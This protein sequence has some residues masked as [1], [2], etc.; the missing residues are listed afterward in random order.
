M[1]ND[2]DV[3]NESNNDENKN[4]SH[5]L[6]RD[7]LE[8]NNNKKTNKKPN[9]SVQPLYTKELKEDS[10]DNELSPVTSVTLSHRYDINDKSDTFSGLSISEVKDA[11]GKTKI[12]MIYSLLYLKPNLTRKAMAIKLDVPTNTITVTMNRN[13]GRFIESGNKDNSLTY[14]LSDLAIKEVEDKLEKYMSIKE[15]IINSK[16]KK[17]KEELTEQE[18]ENE[19]TKTLD[20]IKPIISNDL[21]ILD[22]NEVLLNSTKVA[23]YIISQPNKFIE[24]VISKY[25]DFNIKFISFKNLPKILTKSIEHIRAADLDRLICIEGRCVSISPTRGMITE[26]KFECPTCGTI[27][28]VIQVDDKFKEPVRCS[29]GRRGSFKI[30]VKDLVDASNL[31]LEDLQDNTEN[32]NTQRVKARITERLTRKENIGV[33]N[34]GEEIKITGILREVKTYVHGVESTSV[35]YLFE[36][37]DAEKK[38]EEVDVEEFTE[39]EVKEIK[40]LSNKINEKG[41]DYLLPSF[42]PDVYGCEYIKKAVMLQ[43]CNCKNKPNESSTRNKP[44]ILLIGDPGIAKSVISKYVMSITPGSRKASGG[45][46]SAVGITA[47][48]VKEDDSLGGY[49]IEAG[50]LPLAK[51]LLFLD[52]MNNLNDDDKPK[53][54][55]AM[56]EQTISINKANLHV[57]LKVTA[58]ILATANPRDG[59]FVSNIPYQRQ[60]NIS[61]PILNRFDAIFV[62]KDIPNIE[63][64]KAIAD[65][66]IKRKRGEIEPEYSIEQLKRFFVYVRNSIE[67]KIT[68]E[69]SEKL[70]DI[71]AESRNNRNADVI[72]NPRFMEALSRLI[73]ASAKIRLSEVIEEKDIKRALEV[74][75]QSHFKVDEY[76][77]FGFGGEE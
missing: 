42:V 17:L 31:V 27:I 5:S 33:F 74:L 67:P 22:F 68:D 52:E 18:L 60:F 26:A 3:T 7:R 24:E 70:K 29:C 50:A 37:I 1:K 59:H 71:Y 47:S 62:M 45:G 15:S 58:G 46:S 21:L 10:F 44:N 32:P 61:S 43:A 19:L 76:S 25:E 53:L 51:E 65:I 38:Q 49:R 9:I 39:D 54:Q 66:M 6:S 41:L 55:E 72:I 11:I 73:E 20:I 56:S 48:V 36:I 64:D 75:S 8:S 35:G 2:S 63:Q 23:D 69:I 13:S 57:N 40:E 34:L 14:K 77:H 30:L 16:K 28:S 12:S 4:L